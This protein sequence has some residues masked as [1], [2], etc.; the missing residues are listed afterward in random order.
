MVGAASVNSNGTVMS[1]VGSAAVAMAADAA[2]IP[3]IICCETF[4]FVAKVHTRHPLPLLRRLG[5]AGSGRLW[6]S[7]PVAEMSV[8]HQPP[9]PLQSPVRSGCCYG[10]V[11][12]FGGRS[13]RSIKSAPVES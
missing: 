6:L 11:S 9:A 5:G 2:A 3:V 1:R 10:L 13:C 8:P 7:A 12:E 4:K